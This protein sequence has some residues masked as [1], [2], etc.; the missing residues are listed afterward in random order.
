MKALQ[1]RGTNPPEPTSESITAGHSNVKNALTVLT[2]LI[3][4]GKTYYIQEQ[5]RLRQ[6]KICSSLSAVAHFQY[7]SNNIHQDRGD[8]SV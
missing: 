8:S 1:A 4:G 5:S 7:G 2:S 3:H 6:M